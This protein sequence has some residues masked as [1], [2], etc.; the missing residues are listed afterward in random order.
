LATKSRC[1]VQGPLSLN[2]RGKHWR[3]FRTLLITEEG[4]ETCTWEKR[5]GIYVVVR[6]RNVLS[7][8]GAHSLKG[9]L[10]H[11]SSQM[12]VRDPGKGSK[13]LS[14]GEKRHRGVNKNS[15]GEVSITRRLGEVSPM[16]VVWGS[17]Q[18]K[19][20]WNQGSKR[21]KLKEKRK[22]ES[23]KKQSAE[24]RGGTAFNRQKNH[25]SVRE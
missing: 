2:N 17:T 11:S 23:R 9:V 25:D 14:W 22:K 20:M 6:K 7:C 13:K 21:K 5:R 1:R 12:D 10:N 15:G 16:S 4:G 8:Q 19:E 18:A 3:L 24:P